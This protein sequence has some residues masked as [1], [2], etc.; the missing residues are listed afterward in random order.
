[1]IKGL[2]I[3]EKIDVVV[4]NGEYEGSYLCKVAEINKDEFKVTAPFHKGE[5]VPLRTGSKVQVF[6][7]GNSAAYVFVA[8]IKARESKPLAIFTLERISDVKRIQ[9]REFFRVEAKIKARY[10][11][12]DEN[13]EQEDKEVD[14][15]DTMTIDISASGLKLVADESMPANGKL[16]VM[17]NIPSLESVP[18]KTRI[19]NNYN[20]PDGRAVGL[21][22]IEINQN[23]QDTII[24]WLFDYQRELRQKGLL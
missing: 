20:L 1:M 10:R 11:V 16:E 2:E 15:E 19:I 17:V 24:S 13:D 5:I 12:I 22:F 18:F 6:F 7:T 4:K 8:E 9:R 21:E 3:N 14:W 23:Q